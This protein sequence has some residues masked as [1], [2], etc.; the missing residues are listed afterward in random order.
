MAIPNGLSNIK[1]AGL[2]VSDKIFSC[3]LLYKTY[4]HRGAF[5]AQGP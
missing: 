1:D 4:D 5:L 2:E 3:F